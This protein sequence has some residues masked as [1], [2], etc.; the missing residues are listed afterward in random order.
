MQTHSESVVAVKAARALADLLDRE[1]A[2]VE[3]FELDLEHNAGAL[4]RANLSHA[5]LHN[6]MSEVV[7]GVVGSASTVEGAKSLT[8][9]TIDRVVD[10]IERGK[11]EAARNLSGTFDAGETLMTH[12]NSSTVVAALEG[13]SDRPLSVFVTEARPRFIG[14]IAARHL[15]TVD[16]VDVTLIVDGAAGHFL[17]EV[18]R[19]VIGMNCIVEDTLYNRIGTF[20]LVAAASVLDVPVWVVGTDWKVVEDG[21]AFENELR[22]PTEVVQEPP[23]G[24][25]VRNPAY[26]ATPLDLIDTVVTERGTWSP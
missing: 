17:R 5:L 13:A 4:R 9:A 12:E 2:S 24:F 3:G 26:D 22:S 11:S 23:E 10:R 18:D 19:V 25:A 20:P 14:R 7:D 6:A 8:E 16:H 21:F 15:A 1:Y